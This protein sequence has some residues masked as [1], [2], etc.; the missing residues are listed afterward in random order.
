MP[1]STE[2]VQNKPLNG[3][4]TRKRIVMDV[5][6]MLARD[7][8]FTEYIAYGRLAYTVQITMHMDNLSFPEHRAIVRTKRDGVVEGTP[9]LVEPSDED[10]EL[11]LERDRVIDSP[12][13]VRI[14]SDMPI[15]VQTVQE[16]KLAT[17]ELRYDKQHVPPSGS[18]T[19][20]PSKKRAKREMVS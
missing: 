12:N 18:V 8:M 9:P 20:K 10:V 1:L 4:E 3:I 2:T 14:E 15:T 6:E 7:G 11:V 17:R 13:A 19:D 5:D 16:G